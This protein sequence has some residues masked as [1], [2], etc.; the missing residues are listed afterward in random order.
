[1]KKTTHGPNGNINRRYKTLKGKKNSGTEMKHGLMR[2]T[3]G[4]KQADKR[5]QQLE[6]RIIEMIRSEK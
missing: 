2:F 5:N 1:M 6:D 4:H 3:S